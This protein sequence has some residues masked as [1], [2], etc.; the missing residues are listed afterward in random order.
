MVIVRLIS[1]IS[2]GEKLD[3]TISEGNAFYRLFT[4]GI[5]LFRIMASG[6]ARREF[7]NTLLPVDIGGIDIFFIDKMIADGAVRFPG[8]QRIIIQRIDGIVVRSHI[9]GLDARLDTDIRFQYFLQSVLR[10]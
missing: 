9:T 6:S 1:K 3:I 2:G 7:F 4:I 8:L 10:L 5:G